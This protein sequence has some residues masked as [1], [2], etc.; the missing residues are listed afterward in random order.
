MSTGSLP[1]ENLTNWQDCADVVSRN[2]ESDDVSAIHV[3]IH[4][5]ISVNGEDAIH[6][7]MVWHGKSTTSEREVV[8]IASPVI[9]ESGD[10]MALAAAADS[11]PLGALRTM[12][13]LV[14]VHESL[15][16]GT[17]PPLR[18]IGAVRLIATEAAITASEAI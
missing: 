5:P 14:H 7:A 12:G 11:L 13:G 16:I 2:F 6:P 18:L 9:A 15:V 4:V 3:R 1:P 10:M 17:L 8:H